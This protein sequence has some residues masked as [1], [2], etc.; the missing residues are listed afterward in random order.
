MSIID[1]TLIALSVVAVLAIVV[2][3]T[4]LLIHRLRRGES[5]PKSFGEWVRNILQAIWGL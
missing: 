4:W 1:L 5:E 2:Y 3:S